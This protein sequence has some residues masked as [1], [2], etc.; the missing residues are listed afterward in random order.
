MVIKRERARS[1]WNSQPSVR[2]ISDTDERAV[3]DFIE[4]G[5]S[6]F[7]NVEDALAKLDLIAPDGSLRNAAVEL[8]CEGSDTYPRMKLGLPGGNTNDCPTRPINNCISAPCNTSM[9]TPPL[10][11]KP[12]AR[13]PFSP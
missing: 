11:L 4:R 10:H 2:P 7:A 12:S 3:R 1:P 9:A 5:G 8:F 13:M 6:G